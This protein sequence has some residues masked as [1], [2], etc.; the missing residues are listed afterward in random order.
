M[1]TFTQRK[2][3]TA[4]SVIL[5]ISLFVTLFNISRTEIFS[6]NDSQIIGNFIEWFGVLYG[7]MLALVVVEVWR[8]YNLINNEVDREADALVLLLKTA[9]YLGNS[10]AVV[11]LA[12]KTKAYAES[13]LELGVK[14]TQADGVA[15]DCMD[16]IHDELGAILKTNKAPGALIP[17][18][19]RYLNEAYDL[20][21]D[22]LTH[23]RE[24]MPKELW[25]MVIF[26]SLVW[27]IGFFGLK[28]E[29]DYLAITMCSVA[30]FT[31]SA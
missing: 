6:Q 8:R 14:D 10:P 1:D 31:V 2:F 21:G 18:M 26:T 12:H 17:E 7:V 9:R 29:N 3:F 23:V 11:Q 15:N 25:F 28:I 30:T 27:I 19:M 20:R 4:L 22:R 24:R 5:L 16:A 13:V